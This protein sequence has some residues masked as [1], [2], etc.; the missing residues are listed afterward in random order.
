MLHDDVLLVRR[1]RPLV[2][3][4]LQPVNERRRRRHTLTRPPSI[5]EI[6]NYW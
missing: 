1:G 3:V 2:H 6:E 4:R 5:D